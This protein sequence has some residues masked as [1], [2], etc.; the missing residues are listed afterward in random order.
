MTLERRVLI[1]IWIAS[2]IAVVLFIPKHKRREAIVVLLTCQAI[3][4][5]NGI[6]HVEFGLLAFPVREFPR[7]TKLLFT[8]EYMMYPLMCA[9]YFIYEPHSR[10]LLRLPYL[11]AWISGLT[12][13]DVMIER[14]TNLIEYVN[15]FWYWTW[16][17]FFLIFL[18]TNVYCKWYFKPGVFKI[19]RSTAR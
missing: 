10:K 12:M 11:V 18:L 13:V 2:I 7:A 17:D 9:F 6:L 19:D 16:I 4:W 14:Y 8:S 5:L 15:Y 3:T 1:M